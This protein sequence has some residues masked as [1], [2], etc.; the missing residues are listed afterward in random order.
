[1]DPINYSVVEMSH[2][3]KRKQRGIVYGFIEHIDG[4]MPVLLETDVM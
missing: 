1:M 2:S 4:P 3:A